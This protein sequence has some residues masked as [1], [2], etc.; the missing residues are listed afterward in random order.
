MTAAL[1]ASELPEFDI[2][3][4]PAEFSPFMRPLDQNS[5]NN[6]GDEKLF[7]Q[8][9]TEAVLQP[10]ESAKA[11]RPIFKDVD[12]VILRTPGSQLTSIVAPVKG[13]YL[14]RFGAKYHAWKAGQG[15]E[16]MG[17]PLATFPFLIGKPSLV[18]ELNAMNIRTVEQLAGMADGHKQKIMGGFELSRRAAEW[19][20]QTQ[21]TDAKVAQMATENEQ[22]KARLAALEQLMNQA[23]I[24]AEAPA[25]K[26]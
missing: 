26:G 19:I 17:T 15:E 21:G 23:N 4:I 1:Q 9:K 16:V 14:Q 24:K 12:M 10:A 22:L 3:M 7:V 13:E 2:S 8:F 18:A 6:S 20:D 11:G 25:K 5:R